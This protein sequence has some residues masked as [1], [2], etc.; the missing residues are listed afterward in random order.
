MMRIRRREPVRAGVP[1]VGLEPSCLAV[2][3]DE[4][5][6]LLPDDADAHRLA[7]STVTLAELLTRVG[8]R[9][10][11]LE[12]DALV[13]RH[14][15]H[16]AVLGAQADTALME[17]MRLRVR[18][19]DSGCCGMAGSFGYEAGRR[20]EVSVAAGERVILPE[21]RAASADTI[22][23]ADGFS[24]RSQIEQGTSRQ[25]LHLAEVLALALRHGVRGPVPG[26]PERAWRMDGRRS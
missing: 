7:T 25:A 6:N 16:A 5:R 2:F 1:L 26:P 17:A 3:R 11:R 14:C 23:L 18:Q 21:V 20:Y 12:R 19:P 13:Q 4:L 15:H 22:V 9:P 10:P 24:C 8:Y